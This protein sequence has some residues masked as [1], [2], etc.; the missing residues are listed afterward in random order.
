LPART[1]AVIDIGATAMRLR[2][3]ELRAD[4]STHSLAEL[5]QAVR[6]GKDTFTEGFIKPSTMEECVAI[7]QTY[8]RVLKEYDIAQPGQVR[9]V[10][11]SAV[12]EA[13]NRDAFLDRLFMATQINVEAIEGPV[14]NRLTY[15]AVQDLLEKLPALHGADTVIGEVGGGSTDL[16]FVREGRVTYSGTYRLGSLRLRET[17]EQYRTPAGRMRAVLDQQIRRSVDQLQRNSP[18]K[19]T[20]YLV[21]ISG[22]AR[23]VASCVE[24]N[25]EKQG[26]HR[27]SL[28]SFAKAAAPLIAASV[29][30][31]VRRHHIAQQEAETIGPALLAYEHLARAMNVEEFIV[32]RAT[33]RDGLLKEMALGGAWTSEFVEQAVHAAKLMGA[34][35]W[36]DE[37]HAER[38]SDL[39]LRL[40][41]ELHREHALDQR[42]ALLLQIAALL[43]EVGR[44]VNDRS[45]HKHSMYIVMNS[46]LFGLSKHD[47]TLIGLVTRYHRRAM[48]QTYHEEYTSLSREDRLIVL[49]LSAILRI[50]DALDR[51][52]QQ[53]LEKIRFSREADNFVITVDEPADLMLETVALKEKANLFQQIFGMGVVL[54]GVTGEQEVFERG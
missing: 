18:V 3:A 2:I 11:T 10:A 41:R 48:P 22:D 13:Q 32:T 45:H 4:G 49:K 36:V 44:F 31:L 6:L 9:A 16:I 38:V 17:L 5:Q 27:M 19:Q 33:L 8:R 53:P 24:P 34:R 29:D 42:Y 39:S 30:E 1:V 28:D 47:L 52:R 7:L 43:H 15:I 14:E 12:R 26:F 20:P 50:A 51:R 23:Y 35:Y 37:S 25:W 40:F 54:R 46:D 21:A